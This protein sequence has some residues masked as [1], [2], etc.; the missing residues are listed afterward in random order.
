[1]SFVDELKR[2]NVIRVA[3]GY[4]AGAWLLVQII[5]TLSGFFGWSPEV[6]RMAVVVLAIGILPA[7]VLTWVFEWT[8]EGLVRDTG[9]RAPETV[10]RQR[11][12]DRV[13]IVLLVMAVAYFSF[14]KFVLDP[15]RDA[16]REQQVA[17]EARSDALI[18]SYADRSIVVLPFLNMS[19]DAEQE[20]FADGIT[21]ELL[22]LLARIP[23]LRVISRSSSFYFKGQAV[24]ATDVAEQLN[25]NYVLEGSIRRAGQ[26]FRI[27]AQLIDGRTDTHMWSDTYDRD[28]E[29]NEILQVQDEIAAL[30]VGE[31]KLSLLEPRTEPIDPE[32][33]QIGMQVT[34]LLNLYD[35]ENVPAIEE[36]IDR[37]LALDP[38]NVRLLWQQHRLISHKSFWGMIPREEGDSLTA[39]LDARLRILDTNRLSWI[40]H[41]IRDNPSGAEDAQLVA[42]MYNLAPTEPNNVEA[43]ARFARQLGDFDVAITLGE[44]LVDRDPLC[45]RCFFRLGN[46][47][48]EAFEFDAAVAPLEKAMILGAGNLQPRTSLGLAHLFA[49]RPREAIEH[50]EAAPQAAHRILYLLM[51]YH[52]L[53]MDDEVAAL[54]NEL[55]ALDEPD[56]VAHVRATFAA[57]SG[58][59]D[60]AFPHLQQDIQDVPR[61]AGTFFYD[62]SFM[63]IADD[64]RWQ[65]LM[66][67]LGTTPEDILAQKIDIELPDVPRRS[68]ATGSSDQ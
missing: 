48:L 45:G 30:V 66:E 47:Y 38:D 39:E 2:R 31:L 21:E 44:Y 35:P 20:Y 17:R 33:Y 55:D 10:D 62:A 28:F 59:P 19:N 42:E 51:A 64:P 40:P 24:K 26:L 36:L 22:N 60:A 7:L 25:V 1:M 6:G 49:G 56:N 8:P 46:T 14:D 57:W 43:V 11:T 13:V 3:L 41:E 34:Y 63:R 53:G 67:E 4:L 5:D 9:E 65:V 52:D 18:E 12:F 54:S 29:L 61:E 58:D 16:A 68:A 15:A 37:G 50:L 23:E 27:T 32:L